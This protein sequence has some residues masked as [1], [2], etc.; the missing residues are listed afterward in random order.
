[1]ASAPTP[2]LVIQETA[3]SYSMEEEAQTFRPTLFIE[4]ETKSPEAQAY[5]DALILE[6]FLKNNATPLQHD[7]SGAAFKQQTDTTPI[8]SGIIRV[9]SKKTLNRVVSFSDI[10]EER[11]ISPDH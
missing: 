3:P 8:T 4:T 6:E 1:M 5:E 9:S 2:F 7:I 11:A 10:I